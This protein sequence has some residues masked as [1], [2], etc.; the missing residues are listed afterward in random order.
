MFRGKPAI[1]RYD[2]PFTPFHS[3]S[4]NYATFTRSIH[5]NLAMERSPRFGYNRSN[6]TRYCFSALPLLT[7][8][9]SKDLRTVAF[10]KA[11]N[12]ATPIN[13]LTHYA[14]GTSSFIKCP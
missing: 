8:G 13:L 5:Y 9:I 3:S 14:K 10:A 7:V 12:L 11:L 1:T 2:W 4:E 6:L